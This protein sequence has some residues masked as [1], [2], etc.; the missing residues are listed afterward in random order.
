M[1]YYNYPIDFNHIN[2]CGFKDKHEAFENLCKEYI[3]LRENC[4]ETFQI[5]EWYPAIEASPIKN[6]DWIY[7][8]FQ[9]KLS[10]SDIVK[11]I[12]DSFFNGIDHKFK[13]EDL[14]NINRLYII[15][16]KTL[17][18]SSR[19]GINS[20]LKSIKEELEVIYITWPELQN[21]LKKHQYTH[22]RQKYF[23][24]ELVAE[25]FHKNNYTENTDDTEETIC[26]LD[27][28]PSC[29][30]INTVN[31]IY[32]TYH[33]NKLGYAWTASFDV[34]SGLEQFIFDKK[35]D[36]FH[37]HTLF[38]TLGLWDFLEFSRWEIE[39]ILWREWT[40][41]KC[42]MNEDDAK[43]G[44]VLQHHVNQQA[45]ITVSETWKCIYVKINQVEWS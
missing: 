39:K 31:R 43:R 7:I 3:E 9:A 42:L 30:E 34:I 1:V 15:I 41:I 10:N 22:L 11:Q 18:N 29:D 12:K 45:K 19:E 13:E 35:S 23:F 16:S 5:I 8:A 38:R 17:T 25:E 32:R 6:K 44:I 21:D 36:T 37:D 40:E 26:S 28:T 20:K 27:W 33:Y 24:N 4:I 2:Q 14:E